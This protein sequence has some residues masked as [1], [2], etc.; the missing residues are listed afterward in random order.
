ME[1]HPW[2]E[3]TL[4]KQFVTAVCNAALLVN[5]AP[6]AVLNSADRTRTVLV[7]FDGRY[8]NAPL[9]GPGRVIDS[10]E[11]SGCPTAARSW[12]ASRSNSVVAV[13]V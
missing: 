1:Q 12:I 6:C 5:A 2:P 4:V 13:I 8:E 7:V 3:L 11:T 10:R 9:D